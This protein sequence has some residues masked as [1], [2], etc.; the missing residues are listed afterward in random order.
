MRA[1][2]KAIRKKGG[3]T[4]VH[5]PLFSI[6]TTVYNRENYISDAIES[7]LESSFDD[8]ELIL[9]DDC[10]ADKSFEI[11]KRFAERDSRIRVYQNPQNLGDYANRNQAASHAKG[12]YLKYIDSDCCIYPYTLGI[13]KNLV[14]HF[15][16]A[17]LIL[18]ASP[19]DRMPPF[20][21]SPRESLLVHF[22]EYQLL[23]R[24]PGSA[25][26]LRSAFD[27]VG[28]FPNV[29][30]FGDSSLWL[31]LAAK[32][33]VLAAPE[34]WYWDRILETNEKMIRL[35]TIKPIAEQLEHE[36]RFLSDKNLP[37]STEERE[38]FR[39]CIITKARRLAL[40]RFA[41]T[42]KPDEIGT[43]VRLF[44]PGAW[45]LSSAA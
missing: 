30:H 24:A 18:C 31:K 22:N 37:L 16:Q 4:T 36:L 35:T 38:N 5:Q 17:A 1:R 2:A 42:R 29:R 44:N 26:I 3:V 23:G 33:P 12:K 32:Y 41:K 10:S 39:R 25:L 8:W 11:C 19:P 6:L 45:Q 7:V 15:P 27:K 40:R 28:G 43:L 21:L 14:D 13:L 20:E 34:G 9:V